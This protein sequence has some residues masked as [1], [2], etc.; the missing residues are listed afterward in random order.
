MLCLRPRETLLYFQGSSNDKTQTNL[1]QEIFSLLST[2]S[3]AITV[4][5]SRAPKVSDL[6]LAFTKMLP[7][8]DAR[9]GLLAVPG[10]PSYMRLMEFPDSLMRVTAC[11]LALCVCWVELSESS[12]PG[13]PPR[14]LTRHAVHLPRQGRLRR[15]SLLPPACGSD[16]C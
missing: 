16:L 9:Q 6:S 2:L 7:A 3:V 12:R 4:Y 15:Q 8:G 14:D 10:F 11:N 1:V 5:R 13:V